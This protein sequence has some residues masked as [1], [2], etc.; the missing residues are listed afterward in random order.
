MFLN[1]QQQAS[2]LPDMPLKYHRTYFELHVTAQDKTQNPRMQL[3]YCSRW[4]TF[5]IYLHNKNSS[6]SSH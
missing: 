4:D 5:F 1:L 3:I 6:S 2:I